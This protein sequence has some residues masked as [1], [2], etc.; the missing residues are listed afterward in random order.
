MVEVRVLGI[1]QD[2][3]IPHL[4]CDCKN[5]QT[6]THLVA[7]L[8]VQNM[9]TR[10]LVDATPDV[11][12]QIGHELPD[13]VILTHLHIGH[14]LGLLHF[15]REVA[16]THLLPVYTTTDVAKF[17]ISNRPFSYLVERQNIEIRTLVPNKPENILGI[18]V[19][20]FQVPHR[21]EDGDTIGLKIRGERS[22]SYIPDIDNLTSEVIERLTG[23]NVVLLDGTF[24]DKSEIGRQQEVP[25]P[26]I[27]STMKIYREPENEFYFTHLN[28][29]NPA[30]DRKSKEYKKIIDHGYRIAKEH[31]TIHL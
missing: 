17:I 3:G 14:Y 6:L 16:N 29:S 31:Q 18:E 12:A 27:L 1:A 21:N 11:T 13:A 10:I 4:G 15:G 7:S 23:S 26:D 22:L 2:G 8:L 9:N 30:F 24:Y 28:H 25:H 20:P 19:V 5:C